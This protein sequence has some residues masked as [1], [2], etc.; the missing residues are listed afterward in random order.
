MRRQFISIQLFVIN[1][2]L[3]ASCFCFCIHSFVWFVLFVWFCHSCFFCRYESIL[4]S[5]SSLYLSTSLIYW[6]HHSLFN[7]VIAVCHRT[8]GRTSAAFTWCSKRH[9]L[10]SFLIGSACAISC[11][12]VARHEP[13]ST[14]R[15]QVLR[16]VQRIVHSPHTSLLRAPPLFVAWRSP[17]AACCCPAIH[18]FSFSFSSS[19]LGPSSPRG[20]VSLHSARPLLFITPSLLPLFFLL[21]LAL[22]FLLQFVLYNWV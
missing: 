16:T 2:Q 20:L 5:Y 3:S 14:P 21:S 4:Y 10:S 19:S 7:L 6:P 11:R 22:S 1:I 12:L 18:F 8:L 9:V 13:R 15:W 17:R